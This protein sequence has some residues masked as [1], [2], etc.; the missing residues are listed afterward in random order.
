MRL[1]DECPEELDGTGRVVAC[2]NSILH[3]GDKTGITPTIA[4]LRGAR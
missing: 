4:E 1:M 2:N 3:R